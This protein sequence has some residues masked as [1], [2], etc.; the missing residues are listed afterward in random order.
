MIRPVLTEVGIFL[1]PFAVYIV[2]LIAT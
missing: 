1:I 2:F